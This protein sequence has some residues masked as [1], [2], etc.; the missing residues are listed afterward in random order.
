MGHLADNKHLE[1]LIGAVFDIKNVL[2]EEEE[3]EGAVTTPG[4]R[5]RS[6]HA[7]AMLAAVDRASRSC[8]VATQLAGDGR[9]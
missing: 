9:G 3:E 8:R 6:W 7:G 1:V 4:G 2:A 5:H